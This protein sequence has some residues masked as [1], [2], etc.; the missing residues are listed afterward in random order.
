[1]EQLNEKVAAKCGGRAARRLEGR[2]SK[3]TSQLLFPILVPFVVPLRS[4]TPARPS[5]RR[6]LLQATTATSN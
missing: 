5:V 1:M 4:V 2:Y 6:T 3:A